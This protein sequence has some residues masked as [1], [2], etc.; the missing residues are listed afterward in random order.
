MH[1]SLLGKANAVSMIQ[2]HID[3]IAS[4]ESVDTLHHELMYKKRKTSWLGSFRNP[5]HGIIGFARSIGTTNVSRGK[6]I[7]DERLARVVAKVLHPQE[8]E[9][10]A[11]NSLLCVIIGCGMHGR[12]VAGEMLRRGCIVRLY[13]AS[14][15]SIERARDHIR[16]TLDQFVR[17]G[18][19]LC[20][21][22]EHLLH[23]CT[24]APSLDA[25]VERDH[26]HGLLLII[27]TVPDF[28]DIKRIVFNDT[29]EVCMRH[30]IR[31]QDVLL[32][33]NTMTCSI[34]ELAACIPTAYADR[35]FGLRF[36]H[37]CWFVD[38]V[39]I[40]TSELHLNTELIRVI[41]NLTQVLGL[42]AA[43]RD[44]VLTE[45]EI[46]LY[47]VRQMMRI[48]QGSSPW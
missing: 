35:V 9:R 27:E 13:D 4:L 36:L 43:T 16:D 19:L 38:T 25:A 31:P 10:F 15:Q 11:A 44:G 33:T 20:S 6:L 7:E 34:Q 1:Q 42:H 46:S 8:K 41:A 48:G 14:P 28:I 12:N 3:T 47:A 39:C 37:P 26:S 21:D 17:A 22:V 2:Q 32:C 18:L 45:E 40:R 23:R 29:V 24:A 5:L 30:D